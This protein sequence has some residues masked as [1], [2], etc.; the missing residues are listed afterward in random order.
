MTELR[1]FESRYNRRLGAYCAAVSAVAA[2]VGWWLDHRVVIGFGAVG[3]LVG[4]WVLLDRR[5]KLRVDADGIRYVGWG[6]IHVQWAEI[7]A[8]E[9]R[10][11]RGTEQICV[12]P[13]Y[14]SQ[15]VERVPA[16]HRLTGWITEKS[17]SC[18]FIISTASLEHG[19]PY[20]LEVLRRYHAVRAGP[21]AA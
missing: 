16:W 5:V 3:V 9:T 4:L 15:L 20:L 2:L 13:R 10:S 19:T 11:F 12:I 6:D 8:V 14:P 7:A 21:G 18:R 1:A 17:W